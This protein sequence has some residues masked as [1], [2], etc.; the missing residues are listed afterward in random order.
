MTFLIVWGVGLKVC[1]GRIPEGQKETLGREKCVHVLDCGDGFMGILHTSQLPNCTRQ[2]LTGVPRH[3]GVP[4]ECLKHATPDYLV[5]G[6]NHLS[7]R[8]SNKKWQQP[9]QQQPSSVNETKL[10]L[11]LVRSAKGKFLVCHRILVTSLCVPWDE[12]GSVT[13]LAYCMKHQW[14]S[15][16]CCWTVLLKKRSSGPGSRYTY[17]FKCH[18]NERTISLNRERLRGEGNQDSVL[19]TWGVGPWT[20]T[21]QWPPGRVPSPLQPRIQCQSHTWSHCNALWPC[22]FFSFSIKPLCS[23]WPH[24]QLPTWICHGTVAYLS[25]HHL[26]CKHA[27]CNRG[28]YF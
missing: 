1:K 4:Q 22:D 20:T 6:T 3:T 25:G 26:S 28:A 23:L 19:G 18:I 5:R 21:S 14:N 24:L 10:H 9:T 12:K 7:F 2:F 11:L 17:F 27:H 15:S 8:L 16:D 13:G